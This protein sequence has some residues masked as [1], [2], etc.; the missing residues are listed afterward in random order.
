MQF[1]LCTLKEAGVILAE[2]NRYDVICSGS[3]LGLHYGQDD[4][5]AY[6]RSFFDKKEKL[7]QDIVQKFQSILRSKKK[8]LQGNTPTA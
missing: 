4:D 1:C 8:Q 6:L 7:P 2:D 5:I 3:L